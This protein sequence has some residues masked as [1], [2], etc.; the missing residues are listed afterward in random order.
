M[1]FGIQSNFSMAVMVVSLLLAQPLIAKEK[2][3]RIQSS[4]APHTSGADGRSVSSFEVLT[5]AGAGTGRRVLER[6]FQLRAALAPGGICPL[7]VRVI[8]FANE[9]EFAPMRTD[10]LVKGFYQSGPDLDT[11]VL[12]A[13]GPLTYS[14]L[15]HEFVHLVRNHQRGRLGR[16]LEEGFAE[17]Y[18]SIEFRKEFAIAG[19]DIEAHSRRLQNPESSDEPA[20]YA[21]GWAL[22]R[23]V[24]LQ[25]RGSTTVRIP[26][27]PN[28][29]SIESASAVSEVDALVFRAG[30]LLQVGNH[31][32]AVKLFQT[33]AS[34]FPNSAAA[35]MGLF[36]LAMYEDVKGARAD[37]AKIHREE[38]ARHVLRA[39]ELGAGAEATFEYAMLLRE[40]GGPRTEIDRWLDRTLALS[41]RHAEAHLMRGVEATAEGNLDAALAHLNEAVAILP[42]QASVWHALGFAQL[43]AGLYEQAR[44]SAR[45]ALDAARDEPDRKMAEGL[46]ALID[47]PKA[48]RTGSAVITPESWKPR[49]EGDRH[50]DGML[51]RVDCGD[52]GATFHVDTAQG[53]LVLAATRETR[54][55]RFVGGKASGSKG[56][57]ELPCPLPKPQRVRVEYR[58]F[59]DLLV[60]AAIEFIDP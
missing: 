27:A 24:I 19:Q 56:A 17:F 49:L 39:I 22:A 57:V 21:H 32:E 28:P 36:Q 45:R 50:A 14:V 44:V 25:V 18:S 53:K 5:D 59:R 41:P 46:A 51:V 43:K 1:P 16:W 7:P 12:F 23:A 60:L 3:V 37:S 4:G 20:L 15:A 33:I 8:V 34:Q 54:V 9:T 31:T 11:I 26:L 38:A 55:A 13:D 35:E 29:D 42:H 2:W 40:T 6:L 30:M 47:E 48:V 10:P 52:S 58:Q